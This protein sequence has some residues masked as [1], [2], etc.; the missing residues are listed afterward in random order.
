MSKKK[1]FAKL[2]KKTERQ[3]VLRR[4]VEEAFDAFAAHFPSPYDQAAEDSRDADLCE[5]VLAEY[6]AETSL[7]EFPGL[8]QEDGDSV[9][10]AA[11]VIE[12]RKRLMERYASADDVSVRLRYQLAHLILS[13]EEERARL[14]VDSLRLMAFFI[15]ALP[16][17]DPAEDTDDAEPDENAETQAP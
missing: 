10:F 2:A 5:G 11:W 9:A 8:F 17:F 7:E 14:T 16:V 15:E 13:F 3:D 1:R 6:M 4:R 12:Y